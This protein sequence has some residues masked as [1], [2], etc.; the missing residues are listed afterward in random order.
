MAQK[1]TRII[2]QAIDTPFTYFRKV[3]LFEVFDELIYCDLFE[4]R[5]NP[6]INFTTH[7]VSL[8]LIEDTSPVWEVFVD[9]F[10]KDFVVVL[11][12]FGVE[13]VLESFEE[14]G[15]DCR[16]LFSSN[17]ELNHCATGMKWF[18]DFVFVVAGEDE[19]AVAIKLLNRRPK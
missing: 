10:D 8:A 2:V 12:S 1:N 16:F 3:F 18:D 14:L 4:S 15:C 17:S 11:N 5:K 6:R 13:D 7:S 9:E 19:S